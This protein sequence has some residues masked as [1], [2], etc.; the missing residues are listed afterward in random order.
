MNSETHITDEL[1]AYAL[2][3]LDAEEAATVAAHLERC[4]VCQQELQTYQELIGLMAATVPTVMPPASLKQQLMHS[5]N[6]EKRA[7]TAVADPTPPSRPPTPTQTSWWHILRDWFQ[8]RPI[9]QPVLLL[10]VAVLLVSNFQL[11]QRLAEADRPAGFGTITLSGSAETAAA[12]GLIIISG[13]GLQGTLVVQDLPML[14]ES[15]AYQLWLIKDGHP[16]SGGVFNVNENG[17][18]AVWV[19]SEDPLASYT[20]FDITLEPADG[21]TYPTGRTVLND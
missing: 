8:Q 4:P 6:Q 20:S 12:T 5:I 7:A 17:Y 9:L 3:I 18:R 21:S 15:Q 1:A 14:P 10:L 2:N 19:V 16:T 11:R 13:N